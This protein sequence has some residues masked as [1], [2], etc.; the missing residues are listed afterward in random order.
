ME[1]TDSG[2]GI[3]SI[4]NFTV[5][6]GTYTIPAFTPGDKTITV[7]A[8]KTTQGQLT[9]F[10]FDATDVDGNTVHCE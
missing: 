5:T 2:S 7:T 3:A 1:I 4:T 8:I 6:N 10:A 9:R